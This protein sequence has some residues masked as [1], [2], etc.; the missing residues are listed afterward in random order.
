MTQKKNLIITKMI[1][2]L[3]A[4]GLLT[5]CGRGGKTGTASTSDY[6]TNAAAS[7]E[8]EY[9]GTE[10]IEITGGNRSALTEEEKQEKYQ[11]YL[12]EVLSNR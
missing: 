2:V 9:L 4:L 1:P 8:T 3:A 10:E 12:K 7:T 6:D 5:A 11:R